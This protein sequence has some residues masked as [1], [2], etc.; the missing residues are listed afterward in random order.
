VHRLDRDTSGV[1][2]FA[3]DEATHKYLSLLFEERK[4]AKY[5]VGLVHGTPTPA[6]GTIDAAIA[7]HPIQKGLMT[8]KQK[9]QT[10]YNRL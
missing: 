4:V 5:Y 9:R 3:K 10:L 2:I 8:N 6:K 7:E 1:I